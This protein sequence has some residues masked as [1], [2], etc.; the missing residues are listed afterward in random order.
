M[1]YKTKTMLKHI[2][3]ILIGLFLLGC[4]ALFIWGD[5]IQTGSIF[6]GLAAFIAAIKSKLFGNNKLLEKI[7]RIQNTHE[8]KR[9]EWEAEKKQYN[10]SYDSLRV[11]IDELNT[12]IEVLNEQLDNSK[13]PD[14]KA[15]IR[16]EE[17]ILRWLKSE[18]N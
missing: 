8:S 13:K 1:K 18:L 4:L 11:R 5:N 14:Y 9:K 10:R 16:G 6:A 7:E 3:W 2:K 15:K 17:E 12:R